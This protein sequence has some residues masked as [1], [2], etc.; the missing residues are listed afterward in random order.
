MDTHG[1]IS[2]RRPVSSNN[3]RDQ[4]KVGLEL[5]KSDILVGMT[6]QEKEATEALKDKE[7][8]HWGRGK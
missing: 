5:Y 3:H 8:A 6:T 2:E 4:V 1:D 7:R